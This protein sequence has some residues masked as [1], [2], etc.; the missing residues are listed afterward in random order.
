MTQAVTDFY[1]GVPDLS[2]GPYI[3]YLDRRQS[4]Q[5]NVGTVPAVA[6][7]ILSNSFITVIQPFETTKVFGVIESSNQ[8]ATETKSKWKVSRFTLKICL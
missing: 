2:P 4:S 3:D 8:N 7:Q 5:A 1:S 6:Y